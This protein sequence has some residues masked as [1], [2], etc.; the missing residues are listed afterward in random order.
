VPEWATTSGYDVGNVLMVAIDNACGLWVGSLARF[1]VLW[2]GRGDEPACGLGYKSGCLWMKSIKT[3][4]WMTVDISR[5]ISDVVPERCV[6]F[7][8]AGASIPSGAPKVEKIIATL[9]KKFRIEPGG[10]SLKEI[11]TLVEKSVSNRQE[12]VAAIRPLFGN[13]KPTGGLLTLPIYNWIGYIY[14]KL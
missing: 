10:L 7:F 13:L 8:G 2:F 4:T 11:S 1:E 9:A 6:I 14:D 3:E 5:L 12:M